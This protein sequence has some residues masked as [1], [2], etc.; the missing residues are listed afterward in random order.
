[1]DGFD[2]GVIDT[3]VEADELLGEEGSELGESTDELGEQE[4]EQVEQPDPEN[5]TGEFT[6]K[7]GREYRAWL[8]GLKQTN[9]EAAKF[10]KQARDSYGREFALKQLEPRGIDGIREKYALLDTLTHGEAKGSE[11]ITAM[12]QSLQEWDDF[13]QAILSGDPKAFEGITPEFDAGLAKLA[14][15]YLDRV[16]KVDPEGY[17]NAILPHVVGMLKDSPLISDY[18]GSVDELKWRLSGRTLDQLSEQEIRQVAAT[19]VNAVSKVGVGFNQMGQKAGEVRTAPVDQKRTEFET[20]RTAFEQEKQKLHW[21]TKIEPKV[22]AHEKS[23]FD[24][25]FDPYQKRLKLGDAQKQGAFKAFHQGVISAAQG[26]KD[27]QR[28]YALYKSQKSPDPA[29]VANFIN[30]ALSKYGKV[31]MDELVKD[32]YEPFL[33]GPRKVQAAGKPG[34]K[35]AGPVEP[36]VE[37]RTVKPPMHEID[38]QN[39]PLD[40]TAMSYPG[41]R[42][43]RLLSGKVVQVRSVV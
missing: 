7:F 34:A 5:P 42:K 31:A 21:D 14:P 13:D 29:A 25:L 32:R 23:T 11:A 8:N 6:T 1:M 19:A 40:W 33:N 35:P 20:E 43:Y 16:A 28:Q 27:F 39:T 37:V 26:D 10:V 12:Q 38:H 24:K 36:N 9:P 22:Q 30:V 18:N 15:A 3:P 2:A 41:G 17:Q 4:P